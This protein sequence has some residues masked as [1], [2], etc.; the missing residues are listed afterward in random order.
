MAEVKPKGAKTPEEYF[1]RLADD[2]V[3]EMQRVRAAI[4]ATFPG[5]EE[6][7]AYGMP[8]Y[9]F[10]GQEQLLALASQSGYMNLYLCDL[11]MAAKFGDEI[12]A[13]G[14]PKCGKSCV[15]FTAKKPIPEELLQTMLESR[16]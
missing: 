11:D 14:L 4:L 1:A 10:A 13:A 7:L 3:P 16:K 12:K 9:G 5:I 15:R 8:T 6:T 2:R